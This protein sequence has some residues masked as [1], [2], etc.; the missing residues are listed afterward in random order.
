[1]K[2]FARD[3]VFES[4]FIPAQ[5][6]AVPAQSAS[7]CAPRD[8]VLDRL[9]NKFG[10]SRQSIGLGSRGVVMEVFASATTCTWT[11]TVSMSNGTSCMVAASE[12]YEQKTDIEPA[13]R[14][15]SVFD[16]LGASPKLSD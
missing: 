4:A 10:E 16:S 2:S 3:L 8:V 5:G 15:G 7:N 11:I 6:S 13:G 9:T 12:A 1:M 14:Q